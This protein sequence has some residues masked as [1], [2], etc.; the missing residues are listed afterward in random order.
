MEAIYKGKLSLACEAKLR[1][2]VKSVILQHDIIKAK[3]EKK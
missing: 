2:E 3:E 1:G